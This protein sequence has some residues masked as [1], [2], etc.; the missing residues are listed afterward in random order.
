MN[1]TVL[2]V[3]SETYSGA[4][5]LFVNSCMTTEIVAVLHCVRNNQ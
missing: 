1:A 5:N 3:A 2:S 4:Y